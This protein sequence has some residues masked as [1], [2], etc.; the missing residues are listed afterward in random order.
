MRFPKV[1]GVLAGLSLLMSACGDDAPSTTATT[2]PTATTVDEPEEDEPVD[3]PAV[4]EPAEDEPAE[5]EPAD[6]A[7]DDTGAGDVPTRIVSLSPTHTEMLFAIGAGDQV[8]AVDEF[9]NHPEAAAEKMTDLSGFAPNV[10]AIGSYEPDLVVTDGT[11]PDLLDQLDS[12]GIPHWEGPAAVT[13]DDVYDQIEQ[14]GEATGNDDAATELVSSMQA[15]IDEIAAEVAELDEPLTYYHEL[16]NTFF[17]VTSDTFVGYVYSQLGLRSIA[18]LAEGS[19]GPYP[20]LNAEFILS[21]D[22]DLI[23]L[24]CTTYC[25]ESAETV[26]ARDG[27]DE[28]SAVQNGLVIELDDDISSRWGPRI[29]DFYRQIAEGVESLVEIDPAA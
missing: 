1:V 29:V 15:E 18:D 8:V 5:D 6:E 9:S 20:Q 25:S 22:P 3:E 11:N 12:L 10:E 19:G 14:L 7:A 2:A 21:E 16:D 4:D 27:W 13:F 24:A 28:L 23:Y 17:S 26:A